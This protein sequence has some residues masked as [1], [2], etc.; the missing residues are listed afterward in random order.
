MSIRGR[1]DAWLVD[2]RW[3]KA[4]PL[5]DDTTIGR[6]AE[7][8]II[9]RDPAVSRHHAKVKK[10][11]TGYVLEGYGSAGTKVNGMRLGAECLLQEGDV[12]E[13]AY[14][15]LRFTL[16]APTGE[17]FVIRR[18]MPTIGD[19]LEIPT[20]ATLHGMHPIT[21]ASRGLRYWH[22]IAGILLLIVM[23]LV[24]LATARD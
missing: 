6:G 12:I 10:S 18:D 2:D 5:G 17:M 11:D 3:S 23:L 14:T 21:L 8:M 15:T 20:R 24:L 19:H 9:L 4:Y 1:T 7:S 22:F 16:K 13:I